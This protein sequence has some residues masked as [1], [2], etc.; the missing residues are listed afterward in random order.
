M[1]HISAAW[2]EEGSLS[3][4]LIPL[5]VGVFIGVMGVWGAITAANPKRVFRWW[6]K[7]DRPLISH[8]LDSDSDDGLSVQYG[9]IPVEAPSIIEL[10]FAIQGRRD[11]TAAMFHNGES[12][13]FDL[14]APVISIV[15]V[16]SEPSDAATPSWSYAGVM[17]MGRRV[18]AERWLHVDPSLLRRGQKVVITL[19]VDGPPENVRCLSAPLVDVKVAYRP[20]R[21]VTGPL[22]QVVATE[23]ARRLGLSTRP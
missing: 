16:A 3:Q 1:G 22:V 15:D 9:G 6:V 13:V 14:G 7:S 2:F 18:T 23:V 20:P 4:F 8:S 11:I 12:I 19:L 5:A 17:V 21:E 10:A